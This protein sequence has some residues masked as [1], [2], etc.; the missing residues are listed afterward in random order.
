MKK[1]LLGSAALV[2]LAIATP[3]AAAD[4]AARMPMKAPPMMA[5]IWNWT[6]FYIGA[7]GGYGAGRNNWNLVNVGGVAGSANE[8]SFN[9]DGATVGGQIGYNWQV[10]QWVFGLEAQGNWA[11]LSGSRIS[12]VPGGATNRTNVD[13]FGLFT[14]R[15]G[16]A[17]DNILIYAKGGAAVQSI[18]FSTNAIP[19]ATTN[20]TRWGGT[21]GAGIE[22][23]FSPNWSVAFEYNHI[24][25]TSKNVPFATV[26]TTVDR[27]RLDTDLFTGRIN[28]R[29][30]GPVATRY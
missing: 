29:F 26:P 1:F 2:A 9:F 4:M 22:Y 25:N 10:G 30:G 17:F 8:G 7:N 3:A 19:G 14:G 6:G 28:Y 11:D 18:D 15:L 27:I 13:A 20:Q 24:F 23:G 5:P 16:Y 12:L 21:V